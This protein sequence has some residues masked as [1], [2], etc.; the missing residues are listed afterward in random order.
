MLETFLAEMNY[1]HPGVEAWDAAKYLIDRPHI[2]EKSGSQ[3]A[4]VPL[5]RN[6]V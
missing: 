4:I 6:L 5:L 3:T 2:K 1:W